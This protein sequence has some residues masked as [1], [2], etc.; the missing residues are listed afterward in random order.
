MKPPVYI[1]RGSPASGKT[2]LAPLFSQSLSQPVALIQ[3]DTFR[4]GFHLV[5]RNYVDVDD[6]EKMF[7]YHNMKLVYEEYLKSGRYAI[8][9]EGLF[10]WDDKTSS[11]GSAS[12]L[13]TLA[14]RY[15]YL[16]QSIVL[17]PSRETILKRNAARAYSVPIEELDELYNNVYQTMGPDEI[18][19]DSTHNSLDES[20]HEL[21]VRVNL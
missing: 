11:Q 21:K 17:K 5:G 10:S 18:I 7:A 2:S 20:L 12:E 19:I 13:L 6:N 16:C 4:W 15:N 8:V 1:F 9:V 3:H 14:K